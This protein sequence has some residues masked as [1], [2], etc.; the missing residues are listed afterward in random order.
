MFVLQ[1]NF[2]VR[3]DDAK[4][5][6]QHMSKQKFRCANCGKNLLE[7]GITLMKKHI[8]ELKPLAHEWSSNATS[9]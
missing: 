3:L 5:I 2:G 4:F 6:A 8:E 7:D 9:A 1:T